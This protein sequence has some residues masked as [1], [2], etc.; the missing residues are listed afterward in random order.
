MATGDSVSESLTSNLRQNWVLGPILDFLLIIAAPVLGLLWAV[1]TYHLTYRISV[2][3]FGQPAEV[4]IRNGITCVLGIFAVFNVAHHLPTFIRIYGDRDLVRRFRWSLLLGPIVPLSA[5]MMLASYVIV[6]NIEISFVLYINLILVLWD[7][8]HFLMQHYGFMRIYDRH[9]AAPRKIA[10][11]MD[12]AIC[13]SW[14]VFIMIATAD[15]LPD[16]LYRVQLG[17]GIPVL[18]WLPMRGLLVMEWITLVV[19][20]AMSIV[21]L[22]YL[23]WC[24]MKGYYVSFAKVCLVLTTFAVMYVTYV[25]NALIRSLVPHWTFSMGFAALGMVHVSQ[26]LAIVWKY[27]RS[28]AKR[29][30]RAQRGAFEKTF[31]QQGILMV[32][33]LAGY[34][35]LCLLYGFVLSSTGN[36]I[37]VPLVGADKSFVELGILVKWFVVFLGALVFTSTLLHYYYDGFIW[38]V[39]HKENRQNLAMTGS[40]NSSQEE[41]SESSRGASQQSSWWDRRGPLT[42]IATL[43]WQSL[44]FLVPIAILTVTFYFAGSERLSPLLEYESRL[45]SNTLSDEWILLLLEEVD[46]RLLVEEKLTEIRPLASYWTYAAELH[47]LRAKLQY[48]R[49][50]RSGQGAAGFGRLVLVKEDLEAAQLQLEKAL[51]CDPP[52]AHREKPNLTKRETRLL[53]AEIRKQLDATRQD[54]KEISLTVN[55]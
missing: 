52:F 35:A 20:I 17:H 48:H 49:L 26:Y 9:N 14:F 39:R 36:R 25:P 12:L 53:L 16:I 11:R 27:N 21:Y 33:V 5:A 13:G 42:A 23:N 54:L 47:Y 6:K 18:D 44:Y 41:V 34:V 24:R 10:T 1:G 31:G 4:A 32:M 50:Q 37:I 40:S 30:D 2:D 46:H 8:W 51:Q 15:W 19:A 22:A 45:A 43:G 29:S 38:K 28:L 3:T 7:P 55:Q